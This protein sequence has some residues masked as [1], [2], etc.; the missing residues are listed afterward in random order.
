MTKQKH[1][2]AP[3]ANGLNEQ[4]FI[5]WKLH[6][7]TKAFKKFLEDFSAALERDHIDR[8]RDAKLD[9]DYEAEARGRVNSLRE[10]ATLEFDH[11]VAFYAE[12]TNDEETNEREAIEQDPHRGV[13]RQRMGRGKQ[14]GNRTDR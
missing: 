2:K 10:M 3:E 8:W 11:M 1:P 4:S 12:P 9:P 5:N 6:P 7:A 14:V 13:R